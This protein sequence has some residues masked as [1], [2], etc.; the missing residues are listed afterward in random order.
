MMTDKP[1][2]G[3]IGYGA[4]GRQ[5]E[6]MAKELGFQVNGIFDIDNPLKSNSKLDFDVAIDF[7]IPS[8]VRGNTEI[9]INAG[10]KIVI[11]ATG[12]YD[13]LENIKRLTLDKNAA[14]V[15]GSN[16]AIGMQLFFRIVDY[17]S[18]MINSIDGYDIF[19]HEIHHTRKK[20]SPSGTALSLAK[21]IMKNMPSKQE[22]VSDLDG[23][24]IP[25]DALNIAASR[26]GN[27]TGIHTVYL[28]SLSDTIELKHSAKN[29]SGFAY[30]A[31]L[32]AEWIADKQGFYSF[33]EV[34][35]EM[36]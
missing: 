20:D 1:T 33:D 36:L 9:L 34:M 16:Y 29:R 22:I 11:G 18:K 17:V 32:A 31:L 2:I 25:D 10:K 6:Y 28:D 5:I 15:W 27:I 7:S 3:I 23:S 4:M 21:I 24:A 14:L 13:D 12:W 35:D 30:G 19:M 8:A 26:G